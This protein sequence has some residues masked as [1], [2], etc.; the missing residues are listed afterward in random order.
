MGGLPYQIW[1]ETDR[2]EKESGE[3]LED[4]RYFDDLQSRNMY[5]TA[6]KNSHAHSSS[7]D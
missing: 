1:G 5:G 3:A 7:E 2:S 4:R 6:L